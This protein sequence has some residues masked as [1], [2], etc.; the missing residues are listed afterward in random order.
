MLLSDLD[1]NYFAKKI[2][3]QI[4]SFDRLFETSVFSRGKLKG[5]GNFLLK[6][7]SGRKSEKLN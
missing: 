2:P 3:R 7:M 1:F 6:T 4:F 5:E